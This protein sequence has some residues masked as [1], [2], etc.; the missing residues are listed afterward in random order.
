MTQMGLPL[1]PVRDCVTNSGG[2][3][4]VNPL[5]EAEIDK[6]YDMGVFFLP[7]ML[8]NMEEYR[9]SFSCPPPINYG[10]CGPLQ[11]ICAGFSDEI[12]PLACQ[13]NGCAFGIGRDA[14]GQCN[15]LNSPSYNQSCAGCDGVPN[16]HK[17][18]DP[19]GVCGGDGSFD[20]CGACLPANSPERITNP[21]LC[22][23]VDPQP[24]VIVESG[25]STV[26]VGAVTGIVVGAVFAVALGVFLCMRH[27]Q[28]KMRQDFDG[29]LSRYLPLDTTANQGM[30]NDGGRPSREQAAIPAAVDDDGGGKAIAD[31]L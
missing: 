25:S 14:C 7:T 15:A 13:Q 11:G 8:I 4:G 31:A 27:Q 21:L 20:A 9:G 17:R 29:I 18:V 3:A 2:F 24:V 12:E 6:R 10:T 30:S 1:Q 19:C 23:P 16:S 28:T 5:L 26:S 22:H